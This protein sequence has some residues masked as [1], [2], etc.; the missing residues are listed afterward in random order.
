MLPARAKSKP[1]SASG[2]ARLAE[3]KVILVIIVV[4]KNVTGSLFLRTASYRVAILQAGLLQRNDHLI[5][6]LKTAIAIAQHSACD[7]VWIFHPDGAI[8]CG[9]FVHKPDAQFT[10]LYFM[11]PACGWM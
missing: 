4:T 3:L 1:L 7:K 6:G 8:S 5:V 9:V 11:D 10:V 2:F